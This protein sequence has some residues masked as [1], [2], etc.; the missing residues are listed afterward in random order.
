MV[1]HLGVHWNS[2]K[3]HGL[4]VARR[5]IELAKLNGMMPLLDRELTDALGM[6]GGLEP[7]EMAANSDAIVVLGGDG[8]LLTEAESAAKH[9][10]PMLGV[11]IGHMGFM[12]EITPSGLPDAMKRLHE[13][14]FEVERRMMICA[15]CGDMPVQTALNDIILYRPSDEIHMVSLNVS[16]SGAFM[17]R[18][19]SDGLIIATP[20]GSTAYSLSAGGSV[21]DPK[22]D[23]MLL[24]PICPHSPLSRPAVLPHW[25][26]IAVATSPD[27]KGVLLS[28][29]S[30]APIVIKPGSCVEVHK[31]DLR[32]AF[33][34]FGHTS[35]YDSFRMKISE[36]SNW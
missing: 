27:G 12:T 2:G 30:R 8:T 18:I 23:C 6:K 14:K 5:V 26:K 11:N 1:K 19:A 20:T 15:H 28:A 25:E 9:D 16:V 33:V 32:A 31:S 3:I 13:G 34:R 35:F 22:L 10:V 36:W 24:T 21:V 29:D 4:P 7:D 17:G